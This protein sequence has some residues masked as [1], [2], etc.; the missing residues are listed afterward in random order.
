MS[1]AVELVQQ[2]AELQA[3]DD[4]R[5]LVQEG[6]VA[7]SL[8]EDHPLANPLPFGEGPEMLT[9]FAQMRAGVEVER[10]GF[11]VRRW[12]AQLYAAAYIK[13]FL[14]VM[15]QELVAHLRSNQLPVQPEAQSMAQATVQALER[16]L[17]VIVGE[18][19]R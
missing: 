8:P 13:K 1:S 7:V 11:R 5:L 12:E 6:L 15:R 14:V 4:A 9:R 19:G 16:A 17:H 3:A 10:L 18:G 2:F